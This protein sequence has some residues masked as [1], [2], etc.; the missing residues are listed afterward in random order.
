MIAG[1][2][3]A[4][5]QAARL[6]GGDKT[7]RHLGDTPLLE[8]IL[9]RLRPQVGPIALSA[10]GEPARFGGFGLPVLADS[11]GHAGPLAGVAAG[12]AWASRLG[13]ASLLTIPGDT[14]FFPLDLAARLAPAPAWAESDGVVHPLVALWPT[15][16]AGR[17]ARWLDAGGDLRVRAFGAEIGMRAVVFD[18]VGDP[19]CNINTPDD[20]AAAQGRVAGLSGAG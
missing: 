17:L 2:V 11:P 14:P 20:L 5:G 12:L 18:A 8:L 6:G 1:I 10:N 13:A 15:T 3:L 19:F 4:G 9:T 7:L 16:A